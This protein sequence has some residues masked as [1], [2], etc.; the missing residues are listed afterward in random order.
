MTRRD[1]SEFSCGRR[2]LYAVAWFVWFRERGGE[3]GCGKDI[4]LRSA[5]SQDT[6]GPVVSK[7]VGRQGCED[8]RVF[9]VSQRGAVA[10]RKFERRGFVIRWKCCFQDRSVLNQT[11]FL[12]LEMDD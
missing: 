10:F 4:T 3:A 1:H 9:S 12:V 8:S 7:L 5:A 6:L 11:H 2:D